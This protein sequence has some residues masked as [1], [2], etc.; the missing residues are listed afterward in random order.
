MVEV[1]TKASSMEQ[2]RRM[3]KRH[4]L[5]EKID[6][7]N[8]QFRESGNSAKILVQQTC[9]VDDIDVN[10]P[11]RIYVPVNKNGHCDQISVIPETVPMDCG[12][13]ESEPDFEGDLH[14]DAEMNK[15][16]VFLDN[17]T[18]DSMHDVPETVRKMFIASPS[19][20]VLPKTKPRLLDFN[21]SEEKVAILDQ[22]DSKMVSPVHESEIQDRE[23]T[24][25]L[26]PKGQKVK[27]GDI[28]TQI[29]CS[30]ALKLLCDLE[31]QKDENDDT[32]N[33]KFL[34]E[35][36]QGD[37][38]GKAQKRGLKSEQDENSNDI[39]SGSHYP[40]TNATTPV[41][42]G[43][44]EDENASHLSSPNL[45]TK[46]SSK[47]S[48]LIS[49]G[50]K[51]G[52]NRSSG[53]SSD[54]PVILKVTYTLKNDP[55]DEIS[56][57]ESRLGAIEEC[58]NSDK[59]IH[60]SQFLLAEDSGVNDNLS[61]GTISKFSHKISEQKFLENCR[62]SEASG[63]QSLVSS[64][65]SLNRTCSRQ[66]ETELNNSG[67]KYSSRSLAQSKSDSHLIPKNKSKAEKLKS[68]ELSSRNKNNHTSPLGSSQVL[69]TRFEKFE[70]RNSG[71]EFKS[72]PGFK[73]SPEDIWL[74]AK[75]PKVKVTQNSLLSTS[76][77]SSP[78][79]LGVKSFRQQTIVMTLKKNTEMDLSEAEAFN[80]GVLTSKRS[81]GEE[82]D[83]IPVISFEFDQE[84][85]DELEN[86]PP[87][88]RKQKSPKFRGPKK[89]T[90]GAKAEKKRISMDVTFDPDATCL[91]PTECGSD[92]TRVDAGRSCSN[93]A[94]P[95]GA[96]ETNFHDSDADTSYSLLPNVKYNGTIDPAI[97]LSAYQDTVAPNNDVS[98]IRCVGN[99]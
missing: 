65:A 80:G 91:P 55:T 16:V 54:S 83:F 85:E 12:V 97:N 86:I 6:T 46:L 26:T 24:R 98:E 36:K 20:A 35:E 71:D 61:S 17:S 21:S 56:G 30:Q 75:K 9:D 2:D 77:A 73:E 32:N 95:I 19:H 40:V 47:K 78:K 87:S 50:F 10:K 4:K 14:V 37:E 25:F 28:S 18:N 63:S 66:K 94:T 49:Q 7:E 42:F 68:A 41:L 74:S 64:R 72:D 69:N 93:V 76:V 81:N 99:E 43:N 34:I 22:T 31:S 8:T 13:E 15:S 67:E 57:K 53:G 62:E 3:S 11:E 29:S 88:P 44:Y 23:R 52:S 39:S 58:K 33:L 38:I 96:T 92:L 82:T 89:L 60:G 70:A 5:L 27:C 79:S 84:G 51:V 90:T 45:S 59:K 1:E 48:P